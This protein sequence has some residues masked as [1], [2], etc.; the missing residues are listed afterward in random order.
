MNLSAPHEG[1]SNINL[2]C[3]RQQATDNRA[4]KTQGCSTLKVPGVPANA[5]NPALPLESQDINLQTCLSL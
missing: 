2:S 3:L 5:E 4:L 1:I